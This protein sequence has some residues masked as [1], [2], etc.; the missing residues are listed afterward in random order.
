MTTQPLTLQSS[1]NAAALGTPRGRSGNRWL[2][3]LLRRMVRMVVSLFVIVTAAFMVLRLAGGDPVRSALGPTVDEA[4]VQ[5]KRDALGLNDPILVQFWNY[6]VGLLHGDLGASLI[7]G[8]SVTELVEFRLPA[9]LQLAG[10]AFVLVLIVAVPLGLSI[11]LLT[12]GGKRRG[13]ELTFTS[14]TGVLAAVPEYLLAVFMVLIFSV[15]LKLLPVAGNSEPQSYIL[16]VLALALGSSASLSRIARIEALNTLSEDYIRTARSK[17]LPAWMVNFRHALP[18]MLTATLTLGGSL[19]ASMIVGSVLVE[20]VFNWPGLGSAF[21]QAI[22]TK[23]YGIVQGLA[24]VYASIILVVNFVV[25]I[26]LSLI[27]RRTTLLET[28]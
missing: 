6:L 20:Q 21:V 18:N 15:T 24:I 17:R 23:D 5:A 13:T 2:K 27:D 1:G 10:L 8:R 7:T 12:Q 26:V 28:A 14:V 9:T 22:V 19:L 3:F 16:P 4:V 11:A 25:D